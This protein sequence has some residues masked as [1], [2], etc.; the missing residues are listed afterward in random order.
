MWLIV[1]WYSHVLRY[2]DSYVHLGLFS[3]TQGVMDAEGVATLY[4]TRVYDAVV[5]LSLSLLLRMLVVARSRVFSIRP[6]YSSTHTRI[7][8]WL[9][10]TRELESDTTHWITNTASTLAR[11]T[12]TWPKRLF[13][14]SFS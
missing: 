8:R 5:K 11:Y 6:S 9:K 1:D 7:V 10:F 14:G 2:Q 12:T 4:L 13:H 3:S